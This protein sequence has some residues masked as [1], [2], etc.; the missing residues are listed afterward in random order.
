MQY[1]QGKLVSSSQGI[2][3]EST[4]T[5]MMDSPS[6]LV[7]R[8]KTSH[9]RNQRADNLKAL[10]VLCYPV[11]PFQKRMKLF[12]WIIKKFWCETVWAHQDSKFTAWSCS[13]SRC[14]IA[15]WLVVCTEY[16]NKCST[17]EVSRDINPEI[18]QNCIL[19]GLFCY[20]QKRST[21]KGRTNTSA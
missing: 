15:L 4:Y 14:M 19:E 10:F 3:L 1:K 9:N 16:G 18:D 5:M 7:I 13:R 20:I 6:Y 21:W 12:E 2:M 11:S 17:T 8:C